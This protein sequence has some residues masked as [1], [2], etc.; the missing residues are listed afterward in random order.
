MLTV[1]FYVFLNK[2]FSLELPHT[3]MIL[4]SV[5]YAVLQWKP[6]T[7]FQGLNISYPPAERRGAIAFGT[8]HTHT[9]ARTH[10]HTH[11]HTQ[12]FVVGFMGSKIF[13][14]H[15]STMKTIDVPQVCSYLHSLTLK[16][17]IMC[18]AAY[19]CVLLILILTSFVFFIGYVV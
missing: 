19:L 4:I 2:R 8:T 18:F 13:C 17:N 7:E 6:H 12:G 9:H 16:T 10:T 15:F 11:T 3:V 1:T 14:L 5:G